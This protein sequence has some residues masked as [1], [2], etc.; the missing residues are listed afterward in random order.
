M[1]DEITDVWSVGG[2]AVLDND[3]LEMEMLSSEFMEPPAASVALTVVFGVAVLFTDRLGCQRDDLAAVGM[4]DDGGQGVEVMGFLAGFR[5]GF[6]HAVRG[7]A[8]F[9]GEVTGAVDGDQ[10]AAIHEDKLFEQFGSLS[11]AENGFESWSQGLGIN[12]VESGAHLS[13]TDEA[14]NAVKCPEIV[15]LGRPSPVEG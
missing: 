8:L 10:I 1:I 6:S 15:F 14:L 11:F 7:G 5:L 3:H 4:D 12:R 9:G 13:V 2:Q